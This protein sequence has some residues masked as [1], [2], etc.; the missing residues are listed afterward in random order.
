[1]TLE[2]LIYIIFIAIILILLLIITILIL[3]SKE[4]STK[5]YIYKIRYDV[6][7]D[8]YYSML[9]KQKKII[10][11]KQIYLFYLK[12]LVKLKYRGEV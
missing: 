12:V 5:F 1:M 4:Y 10:L 2:N 11:K 7:L 3:G 6:N 8:K 9:K